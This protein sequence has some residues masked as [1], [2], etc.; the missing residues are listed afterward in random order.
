MPLTRRALPVALLLPIVFLAGHAPAT[1]APAIAGSDSRAI[2]VTPLSL[3]QVEDLDFGTLV[4][5]ALSGVIT[6]DATTGNRTAIGGVTAYGSSLAHRA[7]FVGAG[8]EGQLV[9]IMLGPAPTLSDGSGNSMPVLALTLDGPSL[10]TIPPHRAVHIWVGGILSVNA[11]Q[12]PG[13]Y[14]GTFTMTVNYN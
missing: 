6:I 7:Y 3:V 4:P 10:R 8:T 11:N 13:E 14:T 2:V 12:E 5:S 9:T 1:A